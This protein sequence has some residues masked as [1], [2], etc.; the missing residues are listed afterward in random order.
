MYTIGNIVYGVPINEALSNLLLDWKK[1]LTEEEYAE[2]FNEDGQLIGFN[3][4]YHGGADGLVGYCGVG[5]G[6]FDE[7]DSVLISEL[8]YPTEEQI[9]EA[10]TKI[11]ALPNEVKELIDEPGHYIVWSSS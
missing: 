9:R 3:M 5:L 1:N 11:D 4:L 7:I 8:P 10:Q 2:K 6:D